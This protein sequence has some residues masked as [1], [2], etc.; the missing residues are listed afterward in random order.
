MTEWTEG[1]P[2]G[3]GLYAC[4]TWDGAKLLRRFDGRYWFPTRAATIDGHEYDG[5]VLSFYRIPDPPLPQ[6]PN[7]PRFSQTDPEK[8]P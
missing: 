4:L 2:R 6:R 7:P 8:T 5:R 3:D 1:E